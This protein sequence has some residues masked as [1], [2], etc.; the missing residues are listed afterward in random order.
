MTVL[1]FGRSG[2]DRGS[3]LGW[4]APGRDG[5]GADH[6]AAAPRQRHWSLFDGGYTFASKIAGAQPNSTP[7]HRCL[8]RR[9]LRAVRADL[10]G[11]RRWRGSPAG[12][13][14]GETD[15]HHPGPAAQ[16]ADFHRVS[17]RRRIR[18]QVA[19]AAGG[20]VAADRAGAAGLGALVV[21]SQGL[22]GAVTSDG[23]V[24][25]LA[26]RHDC[27]PRLRRRRSI[28]RIVG[29]VLQGL[30][31]AADLR[32]AGLMV[33]IY[34]VEYGG[35]STLAQD[36]HL[37]GGHPDRGAVDRCGAVHLRAVD[38]HAGL[39]GSQFAVSLALVLLM[40][41]VIVR[42]T[43][44]MLRLV[45]DE[46]REAVTHWASRSGRRSRGSSS[47]RRCPASSAGYCW[48]SPG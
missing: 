27:I 30:V 4:A 11:Q 28:T 35:G 46:L 36:H 39:P 14:E 7:A 21:V 3:M 16:D 48:R 38:R 19:T 45:P 22:Q 40:L 42:T 9:G 15:D 10:R 6:P 29:T 1:P 24:D 5:G 41:P 23:V 37:H 20:T 13:G 18:E 47:R 43:E 32:P 25:P 12:A 44:E 26:S 34:L 31:C 17:W 33:A 2:Y 8:H